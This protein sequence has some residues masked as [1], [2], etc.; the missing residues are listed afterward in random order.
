M[1]SAFK[2]SFFWY[3]SLERLFRLS[4]GVFLSIYLTR[5]FN[6]NELS[7]FYYVS[8]FIPLLSL[9]FGMGLESNFRKFIVSEKFQAKEVCAFIL[10]LRFILS[11]VLFIILNSISN[12]NFTFLLLLVSF[13][14][15]D[16]IEIYFDTQLKI[17]KYIFIKTVIFV[18]FTTIKMYL[19]YINAEILEYARLIVIESFV[20]F[21]VLN[22]VFLRSHSFN[23]GNLGEIIFRVKILI[24][25]SLPF[26]ALNIITFLHNR[27]D[28]FLLPHYLPDDDVVVYNFVQRFVEIPSF[29]AISLV[30]FFI[31]HMYDESITESEFQLMLKKQFRLLYVLFIIST[32]AVSL[33]SY[34]L[35]KF[36]F[37]EN[38]SKIFPY[39]F[40][41]SSTM[42]F[43]FIGIGSTA[44]FIRYNK[45]ELL[46]KQTFFALILNVLL[47]LCLLPIAGL[48]GS[49]LVSILT[50]SSLT[51]L[52]HIVNK[53]Q[54]NLLK[55]INPF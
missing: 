14:T 27:I 5:K 17:K 8:N 22:F 50:Y 4:V 6:V 36:Y 21:T 31:P 1:N 29:F 15:V 13:G 7:S 11:L 49:I 42:L 39:T 38:L 19:L 52:F 45:S 51:V 46:L 47:N 30:L 26:F 32:T 2:S 35:V 54:S 40:L 16:F 34:L 55:A 23:F 44:Y 28:F 3:M 33:V 41:Y 37:A 12:W 24:F 25:Q 9:I 48:T 43:Q 53:N 10:F 18:F 20:Y